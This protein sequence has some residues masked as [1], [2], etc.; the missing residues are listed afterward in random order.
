M[1][2]FGAPQRLKLQVAVDRGQR[3]RGVERPRL[4]GAQGRGHARGRG[5]S[6]GE[7]RHKDLPDPRSARRATRVNTG[8]GARRR[9]VELRAG[10][11][12]KPGSL[13]EA[14]GLPN[15]QGLGIMPDRVHSRTPATPILPADKPKRDA[16]GR[17]L[18][19][20]S[21]HP[22]GDAARARK[23]LNAATIA[24]LHKAFREGGR[25]AILKVM[26]Q[27]PAAFLKLLVLLVPRELEVTHSGGVKSMSDAE[28]EAGIEMIRSMLAAREAAENAK[29]VEGVVEDLEIPTPET[30]DPPA[31]RARRK[32]I[33]NVGQDMGSDSDTPIS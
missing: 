12:V 9:A 2:G 23:A 8:H 16:K 31:P 17:W 10:L 27:Q 1:A 30:S 18:R 25:A 14:R 13:A 28:L 5:G 21:G 6:P 24:E 15:T 11:E 19:G 7:A 26:K 32:A 29:V 3:K 4:R 22:G 33:R 20:V